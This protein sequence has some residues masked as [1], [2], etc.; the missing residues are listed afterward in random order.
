M[1][2]TGPPPK[3]PDQRRRRNATVPMTQLPAAGRQGAPPVFPLPKV[4]DE[5]LTA[6]EAEIWA[7]LWSTPQA[8]AWERL[9]WTRD[10]AQYARLKAAGELGSMKA[11]AESRHLGDR[12]GLNPVAMLKLR[13]E[14]APDELGEVRATRPA[15]KKR[16][17]LR[18][19]DTGS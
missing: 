1:G 10:V 15:G 5:R 12:L 6:L 18:I 3:H 7:E 2:L 13:W 16:A 9:R 19:A 17:N 8:V 11:V 14:V 4:T